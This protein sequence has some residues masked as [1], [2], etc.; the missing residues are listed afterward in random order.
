M[1]LILKTKLILLFSFFA[2][3]LNRKDIKGINLMKKSA[4]R[5]DDSDLFKDH[6]PK[7]SVISIK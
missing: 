4:I 6:I 3:I 2:K 7:I 1:I 5:F